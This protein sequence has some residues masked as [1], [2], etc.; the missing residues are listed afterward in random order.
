[1]LGNQ[2]DGIIGFLGVVQ[3]LEGRKKLQK[4]IYLA[5]E[6]GFPGLKERFEFHLYG[7]Y[8]ET[9][10]NEVQ[11][12]VHLGVVTER[13]VVRH[14]PTYVYEIGEAASKYFDQQIAAARSYQE[15]AHFIVKQE[16]RILELAATLHYLV[17]R[18][19]DRAEAERQVC[20]IKAERNYSDDEFRR[21]WSF[22]DELS[23]LARQAE[24]CSKRT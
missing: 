4:A 15:L 18:G 19:Y 1:M 3:S 16:T 5:K 10:A 12:L 13:E 8:S 23:E 24:R 2:Y 17:S 22:L 11:E 20:R 21:S 14:Y 9:L 6:Y 7:P